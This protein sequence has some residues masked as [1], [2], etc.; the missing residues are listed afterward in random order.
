ML[1]KSSACKESV[2]FLGGMSDVG[3]RSAV[4]RSQCC[5]IRILEAYSINKKEHTA[6]SYYSLKA[7]C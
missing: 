6:L 4:L 5:E 3:N 7:H 1:P 2:N